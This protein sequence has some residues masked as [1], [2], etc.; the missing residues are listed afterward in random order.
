MID[1]QNKTAL[2]DRDMEKAAPTGTTESPETPETPVERKRR[3]VDDTAIKWLAIVFVVAILV[4]AIA[5]PEVAAD[6]I[7]TARTFVTGYFTWFFV[8]YS[9]IALGFCAWLAFGRFGRVR[10]GGPKAKPDY[11]KFAWYSML[12]ACGQ[13]IGLIFWSVAEPIML[14][15][16]NPL[17]EGNALHVQD[18]AMVWTYF[19]WGLTAWAMYCIVGVCLAY[20]HFNLGKKLTFRDT[21]VDFFPAKYRRIVGIVVELLAILACVLGLATSFG[22]ATLQFTAGLASFTGIEASMPVWIT[23]IV[24]FAALAAVSVYFGVSKGMKRIS[25]MNSVL[26]IVLMVGVLLF[27]PLVY[28]ASTVLQT[29]GAFFQNFLAMSFWSESGTAAAGIT[30]WQDS[31]NGW[32]TVFIWCW[33]IAFSAFVGPFIARISK[34]R[35]IREFIL[36]V[37]VVPSVIV[38][39]WVGILGGAAMYYDNKNSGAISDQ[40]A[41][42]TESGLFAMLDYVP[43]IG[44]VLLVVATI[45]VATYYITSL[46]SGVH[47]LSSFV[48]SAKKP[49]RT[50]RV[51]LVGSIGAITVALLTLGGVKVIDTVQTGT[52]IGAFPLAIVLIIMFINLIRRLRRNETGKQLPTEAASTPEEHEDAPVG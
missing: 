31:W 7:K 18:G 27:G 30:T 33:V 52:I 2:S 43:V 36:G 32:W 35:S 48:A 42:N 9:V 11:S 41:E 46:D 21:I 34:G 10:L 25:E 45:L 50:F 37:T 26:S 16:E 20:S 23:V 8:L 47:A 13:G 39:V 22:F 29:F 5:L 38:M 51:V 15:G 12:F 19:H 49:S 44:T 14:K 6:A 24:V 17:F 4:F 40:V 28:L 1:N 3:L